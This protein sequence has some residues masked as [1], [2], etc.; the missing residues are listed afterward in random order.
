MLREK[1]EYQNRLTPDQDVE[2]FNYLKMLKR[3]VG[4]MF[5]VVTRWEISTEKWNI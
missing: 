5:K 3:T 1:T 4:T 2:D